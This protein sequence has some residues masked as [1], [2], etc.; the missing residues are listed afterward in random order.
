MEN[1]L[2]ILIFAAILVFKATLGKKN[3]EAPELEQD[4]S[5]DILQSEEYVPEEKELVDVTSYRE[6][7]TTQKEKTKPDSGSQKPRL[8]TP[9]DARR[10]FIYSE[11]FNRK[12]NNI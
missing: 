4:D 12:Y 9:Q 5:Y 7:P 6:K 10:A 11:I 1:I 8:R 3:K 2:L